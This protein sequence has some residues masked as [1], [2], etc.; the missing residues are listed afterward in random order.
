MSLASQIQSLTI[1][2]KPVALFEHHHFALIP[3]AQW[4]LG[5][6]TLRL[7]TIDHHCDT[8]EAFLRRVFINHEIDRQLQASLCDS[9][10]PALPSTVE[11]AVTALRHD[12]HIDAAIRSGILDAA[13][14]IARQDQ[15]SIRS[16]EHVAHAALESQLV[17]VQFA[18][19][20]QT[21]PRPLPPMTYR[22]P[23]DR[24]VAVHPVGFMRAGE[25]INPWPDLTLESEH[26]HD[27][28]DI[29]NQILRDEGA[30]E[31]QEAPYIL[32]IDLDAF[33]TA[34]SM[35]P[36]DPDLF[37]E[38]IRGALGI[39]VAI[40]ADCFANEWEDEEVWTAD[41]A[42]LVILDHIQR[43]LIA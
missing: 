39:T 9:I 28:I 40:E 21:N 14:V 35:C 27:R 2:G 22:M 41:D 19:F 1:A 7:V 24:M 8:H 38:L 15:R 11:A 31:L 43:A 4:G 18:K 10:I 6:A 16:L 30:P 37:Y 34:R 32:D 26:L 12:E 29:F 20:W 13:F 33:N 23:A 17:A 3:W 5:L 25:L 36:E 42:R